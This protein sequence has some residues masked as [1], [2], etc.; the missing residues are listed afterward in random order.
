MENYNRANGQRTAEILRNLNVV[1]AKLETL[2]I[3]I[4][5][6]IPLFNRYVENRFLHVT[7]I[8][9][10]KFVSHDANIAQIEG[11][12]DVAIEFQP[13]GGE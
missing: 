6:D 5:E 9:H 11:S 7:I 3:P 8:A 12:I 4:A 2:L 1:A 10:D 13:R